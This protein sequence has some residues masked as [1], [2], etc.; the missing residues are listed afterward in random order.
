MVILAHLMTLR[1]CNLQI[2]ELIQQLM[3]FDFNSTHRLRGFL[4]YIK[5]G[6]G[7]KYDQNGI[8]YR[9]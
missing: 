2:Y 3:K 4:P 1:G 8:E 6:R 5:T 9:I 7:R